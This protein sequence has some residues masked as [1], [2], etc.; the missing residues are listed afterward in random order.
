VD[1]YPHQLS[2]G[3]QQRVAIAIAIACDPQILIADEPTTALDVT[4]QAEILKLMRRLQQQR[5]MALIFITHDLGVI[6]E[7][8]DRVLVMYRGEVVEQGQVRQIFRTFAERQPNVLAT[9]LAPEQDQLDPQP[10]VGTPAYMSPEQIRNEEAL[11]PRTDVYSLG[12]T[13]YHMVTGRRPFGGNSVYEVASEILNKEP[14]DPRDFR[15]DLPDPVAAV[16]FKAMAKKLGERYKDAS[17][18]LADLG[19]LREGR[20]PE[21]MSRRYIRKRVRA[22]TK[23]HYKSHLPKRGVARDVA[24]DG[25]D[26]LQYWLLV[27]GMMVALI[28]ALVLV[29]WWSGKLEVLTG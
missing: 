4:V 12:A 28:L 18:F 25:Y 14:A 13:L 1:R 29:A 8:A 16:I 5:D 6:A 19:N 27:A 15:E 20:V 17:E 23:N 24:V 21:A 11:D 10:F 7:V 26:A 22:G 9:R 2:G 3:Q